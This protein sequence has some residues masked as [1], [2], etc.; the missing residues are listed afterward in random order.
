[1]NKQLG[2]KVQ[3]LGKKLSMVV[4]V[5]VVVVVVVARIIC[6]EMK[7]QSCLHILSWSSMFHLRWASMSTSSLLSSAGATRGW[8]QKN[9][10]SADAIVKTMA[11]EAQF[12]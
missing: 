9:T 6:L 5:V 1:M 3:H 7:N 12:Q 10:A 11:C 2:P 8:K 4:F